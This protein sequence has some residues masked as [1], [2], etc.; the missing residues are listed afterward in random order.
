MLNTHSGW[1]NE[2]QPSHAG[3]EA[4]TSRELDLAEKIKRLQFDR[5]KHAEAI[6]A[7]DQA[8]Q[9][10]S[11][12]IGVLSEDTA[13][14]PSESAKL[15]AAGERLRVVR[16]KGK[17]AHTAEVSVLEFIRQ[18]I[19]PTTAQINAHWRVEGRCGT[20][21]VTILKLI[22]QG[23]IRRVPDP[24]VRGSRYVVAENSETPTEST[25]QSAV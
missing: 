11:D 6:A 24:N 3:D 16:H 17:F 20:A 25:S 19:S 1:S 10:V 4:Q 15:D 14:T 9:R 12:A 8:L 22:H 21:N 7:I 23:L 13:S 18:A 5:Q 2:P